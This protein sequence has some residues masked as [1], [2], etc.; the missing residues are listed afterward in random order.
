[1]SS[2]E[3]VAAFRAH[4]A[5]LRDTPAADEEHFRLV[6]G[7]NDVF[8]VIACPLLLASVAWGLAEA[9]FLRAALLNKPRT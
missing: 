3:I 5:A 9:V 6:T 1:M 7:F 8:V 2:E 4:V